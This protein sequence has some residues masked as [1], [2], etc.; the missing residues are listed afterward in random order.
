V[1]YTGSAIETPSDAATILLQFVSL[2]AIIFGI[3]EHQPRN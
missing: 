1:K 2:L 3:M